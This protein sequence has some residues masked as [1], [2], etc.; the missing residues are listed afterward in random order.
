MM[1]ERDDIRKQDPASPP[2]STMNGEITKATL[3][4]KRRQWREF[5]ES[6]HH[7]TDYAKL[8]RMIKG[9]DSK[10]KQTAENKGDHLHMKTPNLTQADSQQ[11]QP[12]FHHF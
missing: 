1:E 6:I 10:S 4:P 3:D 9:F 8:W 5:V 11:F 7:R 2:L 12:L